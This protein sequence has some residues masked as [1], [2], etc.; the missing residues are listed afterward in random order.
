MN[1]GQGRRQPQRVSPKPLVAKSAAVCRTCGR[2]DP[3]ARPLFP[4]LATAHKTGD[5]FHRRGRKKQPRRVRGEVWLRAP[6]ATPVSSLRFSSSTPSAAGDPRFQSRF[7]CA[8]ARLLPVLSPGSSA[9]ESI[10]RCSWLCDWCSRG[11]RGH[12]FDPGVGGSLCPLCWRA[13]PS[14]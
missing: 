7:A 2:P 13:D 1:R 10:L 5:G 12:G 9:V 14:L 6:D 8:R 3:L 4:P 11:G